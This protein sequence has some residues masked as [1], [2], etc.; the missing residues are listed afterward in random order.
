MKGTAVPVDL[1][2]GRVSRALERLRAGEDG[3]SL[4]EFA[5]CLPPVLLLMTGIFAFGIATSNYV[6]LTNATDVAAM[7]LAISAGNTLDPCATVSTAVFNAAP[8]LQRSQLTFA[9]TLNGTPYSG[10]SCSSSSTTTGAPGNV[11]S[12]KSVTVVVTYPCNLTVYK[13]N[14]FLSCTLTSKTSELV[15]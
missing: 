2:A 15:Q 10:T 8:N 5:L 3:Q 13:A 14:N 9:L 11:V 4:V 12:G 1:G 7:Q 6:T